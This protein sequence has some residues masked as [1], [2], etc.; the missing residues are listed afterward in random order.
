V[1]FIQVCPPGATKFNESGAVIDDLHGLSSAIR[2]VME[3]SHQ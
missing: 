3:N 1:Q 2:V